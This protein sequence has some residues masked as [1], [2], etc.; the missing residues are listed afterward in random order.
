MQIEG[1]LS[2][3]ALAYQV[4]GISKGVGTINPHT[5][6]ASLIHDSDGSMASFKSVQQF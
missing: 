2:L 3:H 5:H 6:I 1:Q 4:G